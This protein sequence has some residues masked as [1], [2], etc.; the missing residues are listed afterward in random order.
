MI[1]RGNDFPTIGRP[2]PDF[3]YT[4]PDGSN[5]TLSA[6]RGRQVLINFW[7]TWCEPCRAEMPDLQQIADRYGDRVVVLGINK[8]EQ[9]ELFEAFAAEVGVRFLLIANPAGDIAD[10][11]GAKNIPYTVLINE[12]GTITALRLGIMNYE[13]IEQLLDSTRQGAA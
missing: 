11:Y 7:A 2:A 8:L 10:R 5:T 9:P 12:E 13:E 4:L 1:D 3:A 6:L